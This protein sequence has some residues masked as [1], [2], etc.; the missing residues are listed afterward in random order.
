MRPSARAAPA[1]APPCPAPWSAR[2]QNR[3]N[4]WDSSSPLRRRRDC[5]AGVELFGARGGQ[6]QHLKIDPGGVH[7]GNALVAD[8]AQRLDQL[9]GAAFEFECRVFQVL[10]G[11][12]EKHG[13]GEMLFESDDAHK[14]AFLLALRK[15]TS[16]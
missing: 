5:F 2:R 13:C 1:P 7:G 10:T 3:R 9:H 16:S 14:G 4:A 6:S 11:T 15:T 12:V 8:V